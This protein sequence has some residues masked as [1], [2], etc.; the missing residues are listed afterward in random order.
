MTGKLRK[1]SWNDWTPVMTLPVFF[2]KSFLPL[3]LMK[4]LRHRETS[5]LYKKVILSLTS[6]AFPVRKKTTVTIHTEYCFYS[7]TSSRLS[8]NWCGVFAWKVPDLEFVFKRNQISRLSSKVLGHKI[9]HLPGKPLKLKQNS[10]FTHLW[11][12]TRTCN[13][14]KFLTNRQMSGW[15]EKRKCINRYGRPGE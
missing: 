2:T 1:D 3:L 6:P 11:Y 10:F 5:P 7:A 14:W 4:R 15:T 12:F 8:W 13:H 9:Y